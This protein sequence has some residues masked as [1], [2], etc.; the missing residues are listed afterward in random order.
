[1]LRVVLCSCKALLSVLD[2]LNVD[3]VYVGVLSICD[4]MRLVSVDPDAI[5]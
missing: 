4:I 3:G 2:E 1:M 5:K